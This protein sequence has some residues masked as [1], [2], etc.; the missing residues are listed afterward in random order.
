MLIFELCET[1]KIVECFQ[2]H[3]YFFCG[4]RPVDERELFADSIEEL[5]NKV[6]KGMIYKK[7]K[8]EINE[9]Y[10]DHISEETVKRMEILSRQVR[11]EIPSSQ[12]SKVI[13]LFVEFIKYAEEKA[14]RKEDT[15][16]W[17]DW[18]I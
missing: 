16:P 3:G 12:V 2:T 15:R 17:Y 11:K 18:G 13:S 10:K 7:A 6:S 14:K 5:A 8:S 1:Y 4:F 9:H